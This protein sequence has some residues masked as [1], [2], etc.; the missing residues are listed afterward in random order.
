[1]SSLLQERLKLEENTRQSVGTLEK[2]KDKRGFPVSRRF[3]VSYWYSKIATVI[4]FVGVSFF[5][6]S[7]PFAS[8]NQLSKSRY[9]MS[10]KYPIPLN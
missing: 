8:N 2:K 10:R 9:P 1:M 4:I 3:I 7:E 6:I 5:V